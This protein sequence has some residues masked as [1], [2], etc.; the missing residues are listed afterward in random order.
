MSTYYT[1]KIEEFHVGFQYE[2]LG[3]NKE[4]I[5]SDSPTEI[6]LDGYEEQAY[7]LRVKHLDRE[8]IEGEGFKATTGFYEEGEIAIEFWN[9]EIEAHLTMYHNGCIRISGGSNKPWFLFFHGRIL[10]LSEFRKLMKQ[11]N[12]KKP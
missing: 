2:W 9:D 10:N 6:T 5:K 8:D 11:L 3:I 1:P 7:G 12:I 4:W